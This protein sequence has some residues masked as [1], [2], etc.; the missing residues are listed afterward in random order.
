MVDDTEHEALLELLRHSDR[1]IWLMA[2][3]AGGKVTI[4]SATEAAHD[5]TRAMLMYGC[6]A[7]QRLTIEAVECVSVRGT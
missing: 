1:L 6:D 2:K 3:E 7:D 4:S 5:P